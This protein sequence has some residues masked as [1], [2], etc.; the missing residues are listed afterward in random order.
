[1]TKVII[2]EKLDLLSGKALIIE[3]PTDKIMNGEIVLGDDGVKYKVKKFITTTN[4]NYV[5]TV[6]LIYE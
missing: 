1:M 5:D 2:K 3:S 6:C 4:P